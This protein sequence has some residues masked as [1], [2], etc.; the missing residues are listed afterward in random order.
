MTSHVPGVIEH[1]FSSNAGYVASH[2]KC[3]VVVL[4]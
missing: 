3:S 4:R 1:V 2:A